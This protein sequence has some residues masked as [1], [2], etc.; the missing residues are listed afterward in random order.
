MCGII[1]LSVGNNSTLSNSNIERIFNELLILS[2]TRG[3]ESSGVAIK[4]CDQKSIGVYKAPIP[5]SQLLKN[6]D[7]KNFYK[8]YA[9]RSGSHSAVSMIAHAR[10]VTNGSQQNNNNNQP[11][12]KNGFVAVHNGIVVNVDDLWKENPTLNREFELDTEVI[13]ALLSKNSN[14]SNYVMGLQQSLHEVYG[15]VSMGV[16]FENYNKQ[17]IFTN[18]G[19]LYTLRV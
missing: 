6:K 17:F 10:L 7:F 4:N 5:A 12:I 2:E 9:H 13:L 15:C 3:K 1:G 16:L 19:S 14:I 18:H 11:V 8:E